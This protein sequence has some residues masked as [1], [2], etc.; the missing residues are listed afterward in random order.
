VTMQT[1][2]S[3]HNRTSATLGV[4]AVAW[5]TARPSNEA[6]CCPVLKPLLHECELRSS[7]GIG[8]TTGARTRGSQPTSR[9]RPFSGG[10]SVLPTRCTGCA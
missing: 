3:R 5:V 1:G 7:T 10:R 9:V 6:Q 4:L 2:H 8:S